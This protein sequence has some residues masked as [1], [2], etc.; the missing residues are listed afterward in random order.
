MASTA[1]KFKNLVYL[2]EIF[3]YTYMTLNE[4]AYVHMLF[5]IF[6]VIYSLQTLLDLYVEVADS[7]LTMM[8][9]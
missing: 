6:T 7:I 3:K 1:F 9:F 5:R 8:A 2:Y 4:F